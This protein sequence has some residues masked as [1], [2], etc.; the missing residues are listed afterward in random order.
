MQSPIHV[1]KTVRGNR[2][3]IALFALGFFIVLVA[4]LYY[5]LSFKKTHITPTLEGTWVCQQY[6]D[7]I[8]ARHSV[9]ALK[10]FPMFVQLSFKKGWVDSVMSTGLTATYKTQVAKQK[11][12]KFL[13]TRFTDTLGIVRLKHEFTFEEMW[14]GTKWTYAKVDTA[15][16]S[17]D[18]G[19]IFHRMLNKLLIAGK[20]RPILGKSLQKEVVFSDTGSVAGIKGVD[21][22][23]LC[24]GPDCLRFTLPKDAI[25]IAGKKNTIQLAFDWKA[26]TLTVYTVARADTSVSFNPYWKLLKISK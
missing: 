14:S 6:L 19:K 13:L 16:K 24:Y 15:F 2:L 26:D 7:S 20:Y 1:H 25:F 4:G 11:K 8:A 9:A 21:S 17:M 5:F 3:R 23:K 22:Y 12:G 18:R 10:T